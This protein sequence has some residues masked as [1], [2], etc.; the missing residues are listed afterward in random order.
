MSQFDVLRGR[1][2]RP[3]INLFHKKEI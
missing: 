3:T 2:T 1:Q